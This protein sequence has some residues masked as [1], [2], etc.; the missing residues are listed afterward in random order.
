MDK[1]YPRLHE[2]VEAGVGPIAIE[3]NTFVDRILAQIFR[4]S[5]GRAIILS[6]FSPEICILLASK[7]DTYPVL[8]ITNAGKLPMSDMEMRASSL[9]AAVR[10]S[11]RWNLA[12]IVFASETL[13]LCPRLVGYVKRSG[14][15]CGSYGSL[16]NIPEN[17]KV[18]LRKICRPIST[19]QLIFF[20]YNKQLVFRFSWLIMLP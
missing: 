19:S 5:S 2:A 9:Q 13:I 18:S 14:F 4:V 3:T 16:N 17:A 10:F 12:G 11:K 7:Q 1:E 8:F 15:I 6:S 20:R